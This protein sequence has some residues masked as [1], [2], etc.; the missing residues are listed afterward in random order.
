MFL[1]PTLDKRVEKLSKL[2]LPPELILDLGGWVDLYPFPQHSSL[3]HSNVG[4]PTKEC[5]RKHTVVSI[6]SKC[7]QKTGAVASLHL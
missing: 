3:M 5:A 7:H 2:H 1:Q 6:L 4:G